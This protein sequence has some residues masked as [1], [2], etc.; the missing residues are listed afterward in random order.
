M[1]F[2]YSSSALGGIE[3]SGARIRQPHTL[4]FLRH[5]ARQRAARQAQQDG[6]D[7]HSYR[8]ISIRLPSCV[9]SMLLKDGSDW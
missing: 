6:R 4:P 1:L 9:C 8:D 2:A 7:A 3:T 5:P